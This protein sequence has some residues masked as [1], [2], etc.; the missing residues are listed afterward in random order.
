MRSRVLGRERGDIVRNRASDGPSP[1]TVDSMSDEPGT[2]GLF[3]V[4]AAFDD[5]AKQRSR[6]STTRHSRAW[7]IG[8]ASSITSAQARKAHTTFRNKAAFVEGVE[9]CR[10]YAY[11]L[12]AQLAWLLVPAGRLPAAATS[13]ADVRSAPTARTLDSLAISGRS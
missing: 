9:I 10:V 1:M 6:K 13:I 2:S 3:D 12:L 11:S 7:G 4:V 5:T 8:P